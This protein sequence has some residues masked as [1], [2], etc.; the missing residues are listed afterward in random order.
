MNHGIKDAQV[1]VKQLASAMAGSDNVDK[2][3]KKA[4]DSYQAEMVERA[5]EEV[6]MGVLNTEMLHDWTRFSQSALMQKGGDPIK[7]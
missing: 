7:K 1:L 6:Q 4:I 3:V 2:A 5:A